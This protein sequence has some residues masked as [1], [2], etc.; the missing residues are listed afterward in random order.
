MSAAGIVERLAEVRAQIAAA[1]TT[2]GR[3]PEAVQ[4]IAVS[5]TFG[6]EAVRAAYGA[7]Q[8]HFGENRVQELLSKAEALAD[9]TDIRWHLIGPLQS[10]KAKY[11]PGRVHRLHTLDDAKLLA[12]LERQGARVGVH[13]DCLIQ[14]NISD[15]AQKSG[16]DEAG[17]LALLHALPAHP[18]VRVHGLMGMAAFTD[19]AELIARQFA[20][21]AAAR[22]ALAAASGLPLP[23]LSMGMSGDYPQA[24]AAGAT[25]VRVGSAIFGAR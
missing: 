10:N 11:L 25:W 24:I 4:L 5:K 20:R 22:G 7:G 15:E 19:D 8:R 6:P 2:A 13:F 16:T 12:E 18:H 17:A 9:L 14:L 1:A 21:L 3:A 23:E